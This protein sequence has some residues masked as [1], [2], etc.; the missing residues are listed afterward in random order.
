MWQELGIYGPALPVLDKV[1]VQSQPQT[2]GDRVSKSAQQ[3]L[4]RTRCSPSTKAPASSEVKATSP[5]A[6]EG[7]AQ[8]RMFWKD[9]GNNELCAKEGTCH[10]FWERETAAWLMQATLDVVCPLGQELMPKGT[11]WP[12]VVCDKQEGFSPAWTLV[13]GFLRQDDRIKSPR[14]QAALFL[15]GSLLC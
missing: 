12:R 7:M 9:W 3:S 13:K 8:A 14:V 15:A 2:L 4:G 6:E 1:Q 5:Q 10:T 11:A